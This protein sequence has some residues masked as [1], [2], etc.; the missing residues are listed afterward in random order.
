[1]SCYVFYP[2]PLQIECKDESAANQAFQEA[3]ILYDIDNE[4]VSTYKQCFVD[5][6]GEV[7]DIIFESLRFNLTFLSMNFPETAWYGHQW[8]LSFQCTEKNC[9]FN[10][11]ELVLLLVLSLR[12]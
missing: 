3:S 11:F 12:V 2:F 4:N 1:M 7:S 5:W 10:H 6:N 9:S 8:I